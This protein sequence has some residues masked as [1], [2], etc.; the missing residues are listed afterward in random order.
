MI[1]G[2]FSSMNFKQ[3]FCLLAACV[4]SATTLSAES[5]T[6][7]SHRH[8]D[9]DKILFAQFT[10]KTGIEINV[11]KAGAD[12]LI[13]RLKAEG[14]NTQAD[15]LFTVDAGRLQRAKAAGVLKTVDSEFLSDRIPAAYR[16]VDDQWFG[17]AVRARIFAYAPDRVKASELSTYEDLSDSKWR[18]RLVA[19]SSMNIYNLSLMAS[20]IAEY[21]VD[22][23]RDWASAVRKNMARPPQGN[24]RAQIRAVAAGLADAAIVNTYYVGLLAKSED[25]KDRAVAEKVKIFFPNQGDRGTHVN[26]S[27]IGVTAHAKNPE[28][29]IKFIEFLASDEGQ[30]VF[31]QITHEYPVVDGVE[32]S[33][34]QKSWGEFK[35]DSLS[36]NRLGEL[37]EAAV[38]T[39]NESGWE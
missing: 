17:V 12:E 9:A 32:W 18:G 26:V 23:A 19:R 31:P 33:D 1:V 16:D 39:L 34:L 36:L 11:V 6:L 4:A 37:N 7:Y 22:V 35:V 20:V 29:A 5:I 2:L 14:E 21:G 24:D 30:K 13:E 38:T 25:P 28:G 27:G 10:E 15:L 3:I 8:Y